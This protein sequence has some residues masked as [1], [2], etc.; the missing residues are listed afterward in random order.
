MSIG[1]SRLANVHRVLLGIVLVYVVI[2]E[3]CLWHRYAAFETPAAHVNAW[4]S[5]YT[6]PTSLAKPSYCSNPAFDW[7]LNLSASDAA[8]IGPYSFGPNSSCLDFDSR[9]D[10]LVSSTSVTF[11]LYYGYSPVDSSQNWSYSYYVANPEGASV[12]IIHAMSASFIEGGVANARTVFRSKGGR[13]LRSFP[14]GM[15]LNDLSL[16]DWLSFADTSLDRKQEITPLFGRGDP[17]TWPLL[18]QTGI[19]SERAGSECEE[20][21]AAAAATPLPSSPA[22]LARMSYSN[23]RSWELPS[24]SSAGD[25]LLEIVCEVLPAS[26]GFDLGVTTA[27]LPDPVTDVPRPTA[28]FFFKTAVRVEFVVSG[29]VGTFD[30]GLLGEGRGS[31][32]YIC[33]LCNTVIRPRLLPLQ[34]SASSRPSSC[35]AP[36][37]S[38]Q[39]RSPAASSTVQRTTQSSSR[40]SRQ[41]CS[42]TR[43]LIAAGA[44]GP[45]S[46]AGAA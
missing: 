44:S 46:A 1:D 6:A 17:A 24:L 25:P 37:A 26:W 19:V 5:A 2:V 22:V 7:G 36:R 45:S 3:V 29:S 21:R 15:Y 12:N 14:K 9:R 43:T 11:A 13:V 27:E 38:S 32:D 4:P 16:A 41:K 39:T 23:R 34:W 33:D 42:P 20:W 40:R 31:S 28:A 10:V 35:L 8:V 30:V 18:R